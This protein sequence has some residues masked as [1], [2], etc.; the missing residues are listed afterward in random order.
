MRWWGEGNVEDLAAAEAKLATKGAE[1]Q[2]THEEMSRV[3]HE[4]QLFQ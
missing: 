1:L 3:R 4:Q 2:A